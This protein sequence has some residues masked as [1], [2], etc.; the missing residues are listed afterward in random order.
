[1]LVVWFDELVNCL[2]VIVTEEGW[3]GNSCERRRGLVFGV[4]FAIVVRVG[5]ESGMLVGTYIT[6][7][8]SQPA[9]PSAWAVYA[10]G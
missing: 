2:G 1:M 7:P 9:S 6:E 10:C 5:D 4:W 3:E 8:D